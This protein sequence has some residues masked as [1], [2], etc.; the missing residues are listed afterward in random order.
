MESWIDNACC[1]GAQARTVVFVAGD[2]NGG[3]TDLTSEIFACEACGGLFPARFPGADAI[4]AAYR[5]Y[6]TAPR[7]RS[8]WRT[9]LRAAAEVSRRDYLDRATPAGALR[10]LDYGCGAGDYLARMAARRPAPQRCGTDA[11]KPA[12]E[13]SDYRWIAQDAVATAGPF[14]WIT[15]GHVLEHL[16]DPAATLAVLAGC[17]T[18]D[19]ALWIATPNARG[20][21]VKAAGRW[22]R[23]IDF[24]RHRQ[25]F[26]RAGLERL[27]ADAGL[28]AEFRPAPRI[29]AVLNTVSTLRNI[30][31]DRTTSTGPRLAAIMN[32]LAGLTAC[33]LTTARRRAAASPE[34]VAVCRRG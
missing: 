15:L 25:I 14:D 28:S 13:H 17:L 26:S 8:A 4:A 32:T 24:P 3:A 20:F 6:Y 34:I 27:L 29:N 16:P 11:L 1:C 22:A 21:I 18:P 2:I 5:G 33:S 31:G 30:I 10:V 23:D 12:S 19:G 7:R 9:W